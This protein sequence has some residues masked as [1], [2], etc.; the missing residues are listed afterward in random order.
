MILFGAFM[1]KN[2][3]KL[4]FSLFFALFCKYN[5]VKCKQAMESLLQYL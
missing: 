2:R 5:V 4:A 3:F 1:A